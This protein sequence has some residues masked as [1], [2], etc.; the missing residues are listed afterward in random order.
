MKELRTADLTWEAGK[1]TVK[2]NRK[3]TTTLEALCFTRSEE[4]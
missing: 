3:W 2:D 4:D 1:R